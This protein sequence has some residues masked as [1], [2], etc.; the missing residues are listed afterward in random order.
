MS[1]SFLQLGIKRHRLCI[2]PTPTSGPTLPRE[3]FWIAVRVGKLAGLLVA[4]AALGISGCRSASRARPIGSP[5]S[6]ERP[7][8]LPTLP[9][10]PSNPTTSEAIA[11]GR[12]LFYEKRLSKNNTVSCASCHDSSMG[13]TDG[14]KVST[15]AGGLSGIRNAP[16]L[17]NT[18][19]YPV[20]FWDGRAK[21]LEEQAGV[22]ISDPIEMNQ[23]HEVSVSKVAKVKYKG[24]FERT[25]G[26]GKVTIEKVEM[27]LAS[28][29]RT[30]L[31]GNSPFD[32]YM[33]AGDRNALSAAAIRGF[34][35]FT[36]PARGNCVACHAMGQGN[37]RFTDDQFHNLG[38]GY[39]GDAGFKDPGRFTVTHQEADR[40]AFRT[41]TLRNIAITAPY[42]HDGS[43]KTLRD[44]VDF[45]AGGGNSNPGLDKNIQA[46]HLTG[47]DRQDLV[48]FLQSLTGGLPANVGPLPEGAK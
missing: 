2:S 23:A 45:Y 48:A 25:F 37:T 27:A 44:V 9:A 13:F 40:G 22:P 29:E 16:T 20:F 47:Q 1:R 26:S 38:V 41:P 11:L 19:Y 24:D 5:V 17:L 7:L 15:G 46:I 28:F 33:Y 30:L 43:F 18:A 39:D 4:G 6:I 31:S 32:R 34:S 21:T 42:M 3:I 35:I 8:G 12:E 10:S 14:R 36:A